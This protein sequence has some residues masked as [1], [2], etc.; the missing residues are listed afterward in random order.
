[1]TEPPIYTIGWICQDPQELAAASVSLDEIHH[2]AR[3]ILGNIGQHHVVVACTPAGYQGKVA[4]A[5]VTNE[6]TCVFPNIQITL[7][8]GVG[9]GVL[10][11]NHDIRLG[12][13]VV[14]SPYDSHDGG[15]I[16]FRPTPDEKPLP[17]GFSQPPDT[18]RNAV[19]RLAARISGQKIDELVHG[20][21]AKNRRMRATFKRP[22]ASTDDLHHLEDDGDY[23]MVSPSSPTDRDDHP[24]IHYGLIADQDC[25]IHDDIASRTNILCFDVG[26]AGAMH[27]GP[28]LV[29][30]GICN[31]ADTNKREDWNRYAA[32]AA[33]AYAKCL[34]SQISP[35]EI[36]H[37]LRSTKPKQ[38]GD[39]A[40]EFEL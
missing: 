15:F 38:A 31:Y 27:K 23:V 39:V 29:I 19:E 35:R 11:A 33:A 22:N 3:Y 2:E 30:R 10:S 32:L 16:F 7:L 24:V 28:C 20:I 21:L 37:R 25:T 4:V 6:M 34:L 17:M 36:D 18:W 40:Y 26:A 14:G 12:D 5:C 9:D 1:M 8:V 13:I